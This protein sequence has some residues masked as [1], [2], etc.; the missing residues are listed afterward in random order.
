MAVDIHS[1]AT[2]ASS[3]TLREG[4]RCSLELPSGII[5]VMNSFLVP[6]FASMLVNLGLDQGLVANIIQPV[7]GTLLAVVISSPLLK[8]WIT[9]EE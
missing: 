1:P 7:T 2:Y 3:R 8:F 6:W 9:P 5:I 4:N